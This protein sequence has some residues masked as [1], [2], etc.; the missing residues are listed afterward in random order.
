MRLS[1]FLYR[2]LIYFA[3][4]FAFIRLWWRGRDPKNSAYRQRWCERL[5]FFKPLETKGGIWVHGVSLGEIV[6]A[7]PLIK[8]LIANSK[9]LPV[10][11]TTMTITGSA[12]VKKVFGDS[13]FHVHLPYD[14]ST[15]VKR[16]FNKTNPSVA[17]ILE[18]EIWPNYYHECKRRGIPLYMINARISPAAMKQYELIRP[19]IKTTLAQ[20]HF[21]AAQ[22]Q[23][24]KQRFLTLGAD[25]IKVDRIGNLKFDITLPENIVEK[26]STLRQE[27]GSSRKVWI[28]AS[29]HEGEEEI[30]LGLHRKIRE[31]VP[32][33]LLILVPRHPERFDKVADF[34][35]AQ[36][37]SVARRSKQEAVTSETAVYLG[38]TM[39]E[40][41]LLYAASDVAV[42]CGSIKPI[43]GHNSLEAAALGV[44][45]IVGPYTSS[46]EE[47]TAQLKDAGALLQFEDTALLGS[48]VQELL[49]DND[50]RAKM[51]SAGLL[52]VSEN[53]GVL[54]RIVEMVCILS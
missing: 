8:A 27:L 18:T 6:M 45:V 20:T 3:L 4:P 33:A 21:I 29:T 51:G 41:L 50:K 14:T 15:S 13:V 17:L 48:A 52:A 43:G 49:L 38:D 53:A 23:Q 44:P 35:S 28:A 26:G 9:G 34:I 2:V 54:K 7:T 32:D 36:H 40:M 25:P 42:V 12:Q 22:S 37:F 11:V 19:L 47:V 5:G 31:T 24:D 30:I 16:F 1:L 10:I 39:G 46:C